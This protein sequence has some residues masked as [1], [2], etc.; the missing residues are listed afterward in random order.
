MLR[1]LKRVV[2]IGLLA[3]IVVFVLRREGMGGFTERLASLELPWLG[4]AAVF[5]WVAVLASARRWQRLL[6]LE[7]VQRSSAWALGS[8]LRGRF[9][10]AFTPS[11]VGL[12]LYRLVDVGR[13]QRAPAGRALLV[14]KLYGLVALAMVSAALFPFGLA[15]HFGAAGSSLV[16]GLG[17]GSI[18]GVVALERPALLVWLGE[19]LPRKVGGWVLRAADALRAGRPELGERLRLLGLGLVTHTATAA[20]FLATGAALGVDAGP[21]SL[22]IVGNAIILA[23]LLPISVGGVGVREGTAVALL[24]AQ[25]VPAADA[26]LLAFLGYL[27]AQP[28]ALVGGLWQLA[29][30]EPGSPAPSLATEPG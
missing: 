4:L 18:A 8:F 23:T 22:V 20:I 29:R 17:L 28:P 10:G 25:G 14:E 5:A 6:A 3:T 15:D 24:A 7:G 11:T 1:W 26:A 19:R 27:C 2:S 13:G 16:L 21:L 9:V 30:A 12:D